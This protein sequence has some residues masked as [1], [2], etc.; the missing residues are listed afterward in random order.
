VYQQYFGLRG[1]PFSIAPDPHYLYLSNQHRE[2]LAHLLYGVGEGGG[3]VLLSGEVGTGKTTVCRCLLQQLPERTEL[4]YIVNPR[5]SP[6]ELLASICDELRI[7]SDAARASIK[8][9]TDLLTA[10]LLE[11]HRR[12]FRTIVVIDEAQNLATDVLEQI[13]LLTNLE[14]SERKLLQLILLGQ[15]E[16]NDML[17]KPEL[18]QFSQRITARYHLQEL[19][20]RDARAY[21]AHRLAVAGMY[22]PLFPAWAIKRLHLASGGVPRLLN[23]LC[24]RV[25]LGIYGESGRRV[26]RRHVE[27]AI[28]EVLPRPQRS[29]VAS[30]RRRMLGGLAGCLLLGIAAWVQYPGSNT[31]AWLQ[32]SAP[33][34]SPARPPRGLDADAALA[35]LLAARAP[36]I[37]ESV[38]GCAALEAFAMRCHEGQLRSRDV[39]RLEVPALLRIASGYLVLVAKDKGQ[40]ALLDLDG[41]LGMSPEQ[42]A[43]FWTG[44]Y[45]YV[46]S[47]PVRDLSEELAGQPGAELAS[48]LRG[49]LDEINAT[50]HSGLRP[51]V[52]LHTA[53]IGEA[54]PVADAA[55]AAA[56]LVVVDDVR[57]E[58]TEDLMHRLAEFRNERGMHPTPLLDDQLLMA[59]DTAAAAA[60]D[61][62]G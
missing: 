34:S 25:L 11:T 45:L 39:S 60:F 41:E 6:L 49:R 48:W 20:L 58:I 30:W 28:R 38:A 16:L 35:L 2:A 33:E 54:D 18:R 52:V 46:W 24:D 1:L 31:P 29:S 47:A 3:F 61:N 37:P 17:A 32:R 9:Y 40:L 15:P 12:G 8:Y 27:A 21:I 14:T 57:A 23:V 59:L 53:S 55:L 62:R 36:G 4:A 7:E 5:Q 19:D 26:E 22:Q 13:R 42:L 10:H 50:P 43:G 56:P 44:A 51:R